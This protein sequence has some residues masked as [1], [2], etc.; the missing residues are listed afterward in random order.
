[1]CGRPL[2]PRGHRHLAL[3]GAGER[4]GH[5]K[6]AVVGG[7]HH[8][9]GALEGH[10]ARLGVEAA[11][12]PNHSPRALQGLNG[13]RAGQVDHHALGGNH[14]GNAL[15]NLCNQSVRD[16]QHDHMRIGEGPGGFRKLGGPGTTELLTQRTGRGFGSAHHMQDVVSGLRPN[17][18]Q[19]SR[20]LS[21][22]DQHHAQLSHGSSFCP[23]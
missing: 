23:V 4:L 15:G 8:G 14:P 22:A 12:G 1:M 9:G 7:F 10:A 20:H 21:R 17:W 6:G 18:R 11:D 13:C 2:L 19:F 16:G 5:S 3:P